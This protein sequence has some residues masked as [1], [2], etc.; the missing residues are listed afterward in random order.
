[1]TSNL[2][3]LLSKYFEQQLIDINSVTSNVTLFSV[4]SNKYIVKLVTPKCNEVYNFIAT[5]QVNCIS[6]PLKKFQTKEGLYFLYKYEKELEFPVSKKAQQLLDALNDLHKSTSYEKK[7][8]KKNF[9]YLYRTYKKIDY[10]FQMLEM[11]IREAEVKQNKTDFEWIMLSKY[12]VFLDTKIIMYNLQKKIHNYI[13]DKISVTYSL[14]HGNPNLTHLY[15]KKLISFDNSYLGLCVSDLAKLYVNCDHINVGWYSLIDQ[16]LEQYN[17]NFY[18]IYF[19][20]LVLYIY[21]INI[22]F[23]LIDL[24]NTCNKYIQLS[25]KISIF[26]ENFKDY[27]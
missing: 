14:N 1:M 24:N 27:K 20:F 21:V 22:D 5:E 12:N 11:Y 13:D 25:R 3:N 23:D 10:K 15:N 18:K 9:K 26:L 17:N 7:L 8:N 16:T 2:N 6:Y 4:N 19:K